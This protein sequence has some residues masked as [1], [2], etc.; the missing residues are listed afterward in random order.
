[1]SWA[2]KAIAR[3]ITNVARLTANDEEGVETLWND[4]FAAIDSIRQIAI[5]TS[6]QGI[7]FWVSRWIIILFEEN[8]T[9][10]RSDSTS[11]L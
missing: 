4:I 10:I 9:G 2:E 5:D 1:M 11:L 7:L 3:D 8:L 6:P